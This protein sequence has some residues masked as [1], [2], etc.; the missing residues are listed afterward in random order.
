MRC[1]FFNTMRYGY[2]RFA[3]CRNAQF[4]CSNWGI[5]FNQQLDARV[6]TGI[7]GFSSAVIQGSENHTGGFVLGQTRMSTTLASMIG[8]SATTNS[9]GEGAELIQIEDVIDSFFLQRG[10]SLLQ[11]K[12]GVPEMISSLYAGI[13]NN[14]KNLNF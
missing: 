12:F 2:H 1:T 10:C 7:R 3:R 9:D 14:E 11:H 6:L 4:S 5:M 13:A 8:Q